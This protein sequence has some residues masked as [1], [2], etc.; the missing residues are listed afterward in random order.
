MFMRSKLSTAIVGVLAASATMPTFAQN[1]NIE[2]VLVTG[3]R[4]SLE[5]AM[6]IKRSSAGVVDAISAEDIGK[7][8][9]TNLAESLQR[10]TGVSI[11]RVNGEG[12]QIT[13]RGFGA[14]FNMVTLNGRTMPA[15][16]T[17]G[18]GSGAGGTFGGATRAFDFANLASESVAGVQV[19]KTGRATV[20]SGGIGATVNINTTRPLDK[21]GLSYTIAG[22]AVHDT[23]VRIGDDFTP[24][25]SGL[26]SW[27]DGTFG[28]SAAAS[29]QE[30]DYG[31]AGAA[32]NNWN[33]AQWDHE[34]PPL[35]GF[36]PN[37]VINNE[38]EDGQLFARPNDFR[39]AYSDKERERTNAQLTLQWAPTDSIETTLD[40]VYAEN[41][42]WEHRGE[43]SQ[44][45]A[46]G[47]S[48]TRVDFDDSA[49]ATP[50]LIQE[51]HSPSNKDVGYEQQLREQTNKLDSVGFNIEWQ[52]NDSLKLA[53]DVHDSSM[54]NMPTGPGDAGEIAISIGTP[55]SAAY[56]YDFSG[57]LPVA[58]FVLEDSNTP[59][60]PGVLDEKDAG[61][62]QGR[63]FYAA[64][65]MDIT[66]VQFDGSFDFGNGAI[67]FG[68]DH[69]KTEMV[70]QASTRQVSLGNWNVS[71]PGEFADGT[72]STFNFADQ[73]DDYD[74]DGSFTS[75]I[76]ANDMVDLCRQT[77]ALYGVNGTQEKQDWVCAIDPNFT[78]D[79]RVEETVTG[80]FLQL[81]L[82]GELADMPFHILAGL[83]YEET[84]LT[85]TALL[86]RP[87][88][89]VWQGNND[90]QIT[91]YAP[92]DKVPIA[93][94]HQYN[95]M[96]PS[97][98]FDIELLDNLVG[99]F[100]FSNTI[101]RANYG[102]LYAGASNFQQTDPTG[103][104]GA[105]P[106]ANRNN[107]ELMPLDSK[108]LDLSFEWYYNEGSYASVGL[109]EKRV[110]NFIGTGQAVETHYG[111]VDASA[112]GGENSR[113][114]AVY[115]NLAGLGYDDP[116]ANQLFAAAVC[117]TYDTDYM[118]GYSSAEITQLQAECSNADNFVPNNLEEFTPV[119][120]NGNDV[121][122]DNG[123]PVVANWLT[124]V[125]SKYDVNGLMTDSE[126]P[127]YSADPEAQ[128]QTSYPINNKEARIYG[129]EWAVQHFFGES[130]FGIQANYTTVNGDV[131]FDDLALPSEQQFALLGLSDT[132]NI[133]GIYEKYGFQMRIA[134]NW[135][136]SF[137]RQTNQGGSNN[138]VYVDE[139]A[140]WD[141]NA[142]YDIMEGLSVFFEGLN[143]TGENVRWYQRSEHMTY[144]LEELSP[145]YQLGVRYSF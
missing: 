145:R 78:Q 25:L 24:E 137:L 27:S 140:Q 95:N 62:A 128:W 21:E 12:S 123:N 125:E 83:R 119:D 138:P 124:W 32:A 107:P 93:I 15:G 103:Y 66:Q 35:Y 17:Y 105:Q 71:Y 126:H 57:D 70:Q 90:F 23:S 43:W 61:S 18:G 100:S 113:M 135:R 9:D 141:M 68:I 130:G 31:S 118:A 88:Y 39:W 94:D 48:I 73:Y 52:A 89:R 63:V 121:L 134:Y 58:S 122:D 86:R 34:S 69:T 65:T 80:L 13:V 87:L 41:H 109:F 55:V 14:E 112:V 81:T 79:N 6:D 51:T 133:V 60:T 28:V 37:A 72:F 85:S 96:M 5:Q 129:S 44:W 82:E 46:N 99:R 91:E 110:N 29:Y 47:N 22:K 38:P 97:F 77:E 42:L 40:Y 50:I 33:I 30:R 54:E 74:M 1:E 45:L 20:A 75:G 139:Y 11:D 92:G 10:I 106:S 49:V 101:A 67:D 117:A 131:S 127:R 56:T 98:D 114:N 59:G 104:R 26:M 53:L 116:D 108:N 3:I 142:S 16:F 84:D 7:F 111:M 4:A 132:M 143:L 136:D 120:A 36:A 64:Q 76:R 144:F 19:Y 102:N 2:E 8:P 115:A